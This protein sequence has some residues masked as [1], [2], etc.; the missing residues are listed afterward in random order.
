MIQLTS[1]SST[2]KSHLKH[3]TSVYMTIPVHLSS[4]KIPQIHHLLGLLGRQSHQTG[5]QIPVLA[6]SN[7][8]IQ[9]VVHR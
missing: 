2:I 6:L 7:L 9:T 3:G 8:V 4:E 1:L 5:Q